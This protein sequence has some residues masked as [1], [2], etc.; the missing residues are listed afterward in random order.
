MPQRRR[1]DL[2]AGVCGERVDAGCGRRCFDRHIRRQHF[3]LIFVCEKPRTLESVVPLGCKLQ[4]EF[5]SETLALDNTTSTT[6]SFNIS[7]AEH[8]F[9]SIHSPDSSLRTLDRTR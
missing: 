1:H 7:A 3:S 9:L 4:A 6:H 8:S 2:V 5:F